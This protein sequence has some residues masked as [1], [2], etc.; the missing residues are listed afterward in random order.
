M[1]K[2][3]V[4]LPIFLRSFVVFVAKAL[5]PVLARSSVEAIAVGKIFDGDA[6]TQLSVA[7]V[8]TSSLTNTFVVTIFGH[9][10]TR[11]AVGCNWLVRQNPKP[12][13]CRLIWDQQEPSW[14]SPLENSWIA[15]ATTS[16]QTWT[17]KSNFIFL[18]KEDENKINYIHTKL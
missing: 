7:R 9:Q 8:F 11:L 16:H 17:L 3:I 12:I 10:S 18:T 13:K 15:N 2:F 14:N 1:S 4:S 6:N 5:I